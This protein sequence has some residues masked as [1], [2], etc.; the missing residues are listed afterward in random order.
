MLFV[1]TCRVERPVDAVG[2]V[3][4]VFLD[5]P[6]CIG[7]CCITLPASWFC[8]QPA[9]LFSDSALDAFFRSTNSIY[10]SCSLIISSLWFLPVSFIYRLNGF[11]VW[12]CPRCFSKI[13]ALRWSVGATWES[14]V[15]ILCANRL[16]KSSDWPFFSK[17][18]RSF[19]ASPNKFVIYTFYL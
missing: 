18:A 16:N 1:L 17:S 11:F 4:S 8:F 5:F 19:Y 2:E 7:V 13:L 3:T 15:W 12:L 14:L 9:L 6:F 10:L